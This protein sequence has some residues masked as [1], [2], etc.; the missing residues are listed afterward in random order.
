MMGHNICFYG[1][2]GII[3]PKLYLLPILIWS[4]G[5]IGSKFNSRHTKE[6][7][8]KVCQGW[9][10]KYFSGSLYASPSTLV[11]Q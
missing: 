6:E 5:A 2:I 10:K 7:E 4:S 3:I 11:M 1:K 8:E 9:K